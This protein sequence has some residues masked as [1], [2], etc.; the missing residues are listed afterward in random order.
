MCAWPCFLEFPNPPKTFFVCLVRYF[1]L[2]LEHKPRGWRSPI[3]NLCGLLALKIRQPVQWLGG[4]LRAGPWKKP[5]NKTGKDERG[6]KE[7][8]GE[9]A[10]AKE[11]Q[12]FW[13]K[14]KKGAMTA[15]RQRRRSTKLLESWWPVFSQ[16]PQ[17][18][19]QQPPKLID[20]WQET[21]RRSRRTQKLVIS[22]P[23]MH[24]PRLQNLPQPMREA[25][26]VTSPPYRPATNNP[27]C[28]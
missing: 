1:F 2:Y 28:C 5:H 21:Q 12:V 20:L 3:A 9:V 11:I 8:L 4:W 18:K 22:L 27:L 25:L 13:K 16:F 10:A 6:G 24:R 17:I 19:Q 23:D 15:L 7:G 14:K 26:K